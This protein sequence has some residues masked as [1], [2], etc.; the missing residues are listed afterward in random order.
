L[1]AAETRAAGVVA[2]SLWEGY[3]KMSSGAALQ[4]LLAEHQISITSV[5]TSG[6]ASVFDLRRLVEALGSKR[7]APMPATAFASSSQ[8]SSVTL[9]ATGGRPGPMTVQQDRE[10]FNLG[11]AAKGLAWQVGVTEPWSGNGSDRFAYFADERRFVIVAGPQEGS[12]V[13]LAFAQGLE[14][15]G[16]RQLVLILPEDRAFATLQRAPW[17]KAEARPVVYLHDG[18]TAHVCDLPTQDE[19]VKRLDAKHEG[20]PEVELR[21]AATPA[22][23]GARSNAVYDLVEWATKEP[24]LDASHRRGERDADTGERQRRRDCAR[25]GRSAPAQL[26]VSID[27]Y[28]PQ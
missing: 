21:K 6:H 3:L 10:L 19:T 5:H 24:L 23:L 17:F 16:S 14:Q 18:V 7:V 11:E 1:S 20:S 22:H 26:R 9:A 12:Y 28:W 13:D 8:E 27:L 4:E 2:W 15:R 25:A